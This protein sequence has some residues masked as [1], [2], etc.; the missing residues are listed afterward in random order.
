MDTD[1]KR[2]RQCNHNNRKDPIGYP[3]YYEIV[4]QGMLDMNWSQR[5]SGM[6]ITVTGGKGLNP[7]TTLRGDL[8]DQSALLGVLNTLHDLQYDLLRVEYMSHI[9]TKKS[10]DTKQ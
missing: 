6:A 3:A 8:V 7:T 1:R 9:G 10:G 5:M 2:K 4:V